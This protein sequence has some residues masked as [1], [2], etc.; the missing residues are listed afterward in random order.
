MLDFGQKNLHIDHKHNNLIAYADIEQKLNA[1]CSNIE[2]H[3]K[4]LNCT[5]FCMLS[6]FVRLRPV[7]DLSDVP[8]QRERPAHSLL[9]VPQGRNR[10]PHGGSERRRE[11]H[12]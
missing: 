11:I 2:L 9:K 10:L 5:N 1:L 6:G 3:F 7:R 8:R 4:L 12:V